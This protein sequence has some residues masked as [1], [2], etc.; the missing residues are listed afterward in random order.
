MLLISAVLFKFQQ[1]SLPYRDR[2]AERRTLHGEFGIG[3]GQK[4]FQDSNLYEEGTTSQ[5]FDA[6][7]AAAEA[8]NMTFGKGSYA[9]RVLENM[10]WKDVS[11]MLSKMSLLFFFFL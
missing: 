10:G 5:T 7:E 4:N 11:L 8:M 9:R 3:P 2:A 1:Q 6:E